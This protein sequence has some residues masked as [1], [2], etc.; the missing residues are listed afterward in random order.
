MREGLYTFQQDLDN[1]K[2]DYANEVGRLLENYWSDILLDASII[3]SMKDRDIKFFIIQPKCT[4]SASPDEYDSKRDE[5]AKVWGNYVVF[6]I[7][8]EGD[9]YRMFK[10]DK[11][12]TMSYDTKDDVLIQ[13]YKDFDI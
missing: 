5:C 8:R 9:K 4:H 10:W 1:I 12:E 13:R 11:L 2:R 3:D 6:K 7:V